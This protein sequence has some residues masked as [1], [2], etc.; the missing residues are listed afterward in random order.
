[1]DIT[2][3]FKLPFIGLLLSLGMGLSGGQHITHPA[4]NTLAQQINYILQHD[5]RTANI[6]VVIQ[7]TQ[8]GKI[9]ASQNAGRY[10]VPA[11]NMK[12]FTAAAAFAYLGEDFRFRTNVYAS[13]EQITH[14]TLHGDVYFQFGGDPTL[15]RA[16]LK[17]LVLAV[18]KHGIHKINGHVFMDVHA[19][20]SP[21]LG[22]GWMWDDTNICFSAPVVADNINRNCSTIEV[23]PGKKVGDPAIVKSP[24]NNQLIAIENGITTASQKKKCGLSMEVTQYN[25]YRLSGCVKQKQKPQ[26]LQI[27]IKNPHL[28]TKTYLMYL[29]KK[30]HITYQ[31][32]ITLKKAKKPLHLLATHKSK[33]AAV[34]LKVML[35]KSDNLIADA[36][37]KKMGQVYFNGRG[38]WRS[39]AQA[40][41]NIL[42]RRYGLKFKHARLIDGAGLSRYNLVTPDLLAQLLTDVGNDPKIDEAFMHALPVSGID[43]TLRHR[44]KGKNDRGRIFAKTG[45]MVGITSLSGYAVTLNHK[46]VS[47][48]ILVNGAS[49]SVRKYRRV[50][51]Q[52]CQL[53]LRLRL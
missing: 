26:H 39:G 49:Q 15:R 3:L 22:P 21:D 32:T 27:A 37:F 28:F 46:L 38:S 51:D 16:D 20:K 8:T 4:N 33:P 35:K 31:G 5:G 11:S 48:S 42:Q 7:N 50:E 19:F 1:M 29:L 43:G 52:I 45:T 41:K 9:I 12:I 34:L 44:L 30:E 36:F 10:Y 6:G 17:K 18:K 40:V 13:T 2:L 23:R 47:F 53:L 25:F 14:N 24:L